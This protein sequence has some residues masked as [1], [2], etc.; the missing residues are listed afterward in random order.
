MNC[1]ALMNTIPQ[2]GELYSV[3]LK[4]RLQYM[5]CIKSLSDMCHNTSLRLVLRIK[6]D[7][8]NAS[9]LLGPKYGCT[10]PGGKLLLDTAKSLGLN[11]VGI[12]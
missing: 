4:V 11:V 9:R 3:Y 10:V 6:A 7:D 5:L 2:Q 8:P 12:A 1:I